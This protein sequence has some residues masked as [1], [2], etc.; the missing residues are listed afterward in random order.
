[1]EPSDDKRDEPLRL[2][3]FLKLNW[4][5]ETGGQAKVMIQEGSVMLNGEVETRRRKKLFPGDIVQV[6]DG[7]WVVGADQQE[8][9]AS[10][11][12]VPDN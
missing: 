3:Q 10:P 8:H 7:K 11:G 6:G 9:E 1:M 5:T 2:D 12:E 4:I